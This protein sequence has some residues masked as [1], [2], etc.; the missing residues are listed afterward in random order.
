MW[1][2]EVITRN[3]E[4]G[5]PVKTLHE[6]DDDNFENRKVEIYADG[7]FGLAGEGVEVG[8]TWLSPER[9]EKIEEINAHGGFLA[10]KI[11]NDEFEEEWRKA[12]KYSELL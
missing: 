12:K 6:L 4:N 2:A 3:Q 11:R 1:Y 8:K 5:I 7:K 9:F 10:R